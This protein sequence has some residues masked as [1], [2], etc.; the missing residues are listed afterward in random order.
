MILSEQT[1]RYIYLFGLLLLSFAIPTSVFLMSVSQFI[2]LFN[3]ILEGNFK[4]KIKRFYT[5][6]LALIFI[7]IYLIHIIWSIFP[8]DYSYAFNDLR[9]K[10]PMAFLPFIIASS[11]SLK[12]NEI[13]I[14]LYAFVLAVSFT[15]FISLYRYFNKENL[16]IVDYRNYVPFISHVRYSLMLVFSILIL[17]YFIINK[18][19]A[20]TFN[21]LVISNLIFLLFVLI[22]LRIPTSVF[23]FLIIISYW[24]LILFQ[25]INKK[26]KWF[27]FIGFLIF[28]GLIVVKGYKI[29]K[30]FNIAYNK[31]I[32]DEVI[33]N[34]NGKPFSFDDNKEV[35][36]GNRVFFYIVEEE[37][38]KE[39]NKKSC[40]LYDGYDLKG[41]KIKYTILRYLTSKG[42]TKDSVG[43][44]SLSN[45]DIRSIEKGIPN[46]IY[47]KWF[48]IEAF[49]YPFVWDLY[50]Y[51]RLGKIG[52]STLFQRVEY[53]KVALSIIRKNFLF[54]VGTGNV[55]KAFK[56]EYK[57]IS[58][59]LDEEHRHRAHNQ[60][61]TFLLTFGIFGFI[62]IMFAFLYPYI[63]RIN[64]SVKL[65][66]HSFLLICLISFLTED[67]L[68]TQAGVTFVIY[69]YS[70]FAFSENT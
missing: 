10:I 16:N 48:S 50:N 38:K 33:I 64:F 55:E 24:L 19:F 63:K 41:N 15:G 59:N 18:E 42:L 17:V 12:W 1:H 65:L 22:V 54:G 57:L 5:N 21:A 2:L 60:Y 34:A 28:S 26:I 47:L 61:L 51:I 49:I 52:G 67:T 20:R 43:V 25:K 40:Y 46:Y 14:L 30:E 66:K 23:L 70:L 69:F 35:E 45:E 13:K 8:Q 4:S 6:K 53:Q 58:T 39:W 44:N 68:E 3:W 62:W 32:P 56:E 29:W 11:K 37:L 7:S 36:N 9:I 31:P 27:I